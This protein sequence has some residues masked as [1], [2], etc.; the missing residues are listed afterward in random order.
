MLNY[1]RARNH[2]VNAEQDVESLRADCVRYSDLVWI[3]QDKSVKVV[4]SG[5]TGYGYQVLIII[6][7]S[8]CPGTHLRIK[9]SVL[10]I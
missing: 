8:N 6:S 2:L 9:L 5:D 10:K 3:T 4:V 7:E 1:Y